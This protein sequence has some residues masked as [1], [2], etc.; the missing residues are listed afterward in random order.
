M[1]QATARHRFGL[2]III[3]TITATRPATIT[4]AIAAVASSIAGRGVSALLREC[5]LAPPVS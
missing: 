1:V 2:T 3:I 4:V 5:P